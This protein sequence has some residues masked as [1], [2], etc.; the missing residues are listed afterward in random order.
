MCCFI[1][2]QERIRAES[3]AKDILSHRSQKDMTPTSTYSQAV[4]RGLL[5][6]ISAV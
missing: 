5:S 6:S 4:N 1:T 3:L 2:K